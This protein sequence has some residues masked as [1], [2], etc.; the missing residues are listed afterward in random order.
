MTAATGEHVADQRSNAVRAVGIGV[1]VVALERVPAAILP[2][3]ITRNRSCE[4][5][6]EA[7]QIDHH[8]PRE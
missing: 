1:H 6:F 8:R 7:R 3:V 5:R 2:A 4:R